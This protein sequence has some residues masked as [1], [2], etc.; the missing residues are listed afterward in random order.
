[1]VECCCYIPNQLVDYG[2]GWALICLPQ[3]CRWLC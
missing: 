3:A 2:L 1:L